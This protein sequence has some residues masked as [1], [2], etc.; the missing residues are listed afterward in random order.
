MHPN[1]YNC[2]CCSSSILTLTSSTSKVRSCFSGH[3]QR[4]N[5]SHGYNRWHHTDLACHAAMQYPFNNWNRGGRNR[6]A[7]EFICER[8]NRKPYQTSYWSW[9]RFTRVKTVIKNGWPHKLSDELP[10]AHPYHP[11]RD[12]LVEQDSVI[13]IGERVIVPVSIVI[14]HEDN[15]RCKKSL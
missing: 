10:V 15:L 6:H 12:K 11:F 4:C 3:T 9:Q 13:F 7:K 5:D 1:V 2:W 14:T 8:H